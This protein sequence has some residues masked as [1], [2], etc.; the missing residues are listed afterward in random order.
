MN[1]IPNDK[2]HMLMN[3]KKS[4]RPGREGYSIFVFK[5]QRPGLEAG[6]VGAGVEGEGDCAVVVAGG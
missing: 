5:S 3:Y 4:Q 6:G 2:E 1:Y